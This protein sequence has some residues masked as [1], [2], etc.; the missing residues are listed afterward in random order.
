[1]GIQSTLD[2]A[3]PNNNFKRFEE[4]DGVSFAEKLS[5]FIFYAESFSLS[6]SRRTLKRKNE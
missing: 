3:L 5:I 2:G 4:R 1:M 6:E